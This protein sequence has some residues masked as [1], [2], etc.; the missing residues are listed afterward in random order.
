MVGLGQRMARL[1]RAPAQWVSA[2]AFV[3]CIL[4]VLPAMPAGSDPID[5]RV[6]SV[7]GA[8][9]EVVFALGAQDRLIAVDS[10]SQ[11]PREA[12]DLPDVGYMRQ[13]AAEPILALAPSLVLVEEDAGP[14]EV[15]DQL[16]AANVDLVVVADDP[17][18]Q[19]VLAK[20]EAVAS[21]L[22][23]EAQGREIAARLQT[24]FARLE[25][26]IAPA[27]T[28]PR[29]LFLLSIGDG[30]PLAAGVGTSAAGII[31]LAGGENAIDGFEG[32]KPLTPE[33][34]ATAAPDVLLVTTRTLEALG[35]PQAV[36]A[37]P[38]V[39]ATKAGRDGRLVALDGLL[40]LGFGPRTPEAIRAL[41][42][43][44]HP[45]LVLPQGSE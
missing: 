43:A 22:G 16:R 40:L 17:S 30:A 41:A 23:L 11:Y 12:Q 13:L 32:Y 8:I 5:T 10:T 42:G 24:E 38:E 1:V 15:L 28:R 34:A 45:G 18:P 9:T 27:A 2:P 19:G 35:G 6:I 36:L 31:A 14:P 44:L 39:A 7:G 3:V 21:A 26:A 29:V 37:R 4:A 33:A 20:I 25:D